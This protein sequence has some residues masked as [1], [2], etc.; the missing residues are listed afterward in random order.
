MLGIEGLSVRLSW[1]AR[2]WVRP[3]MVMLS[4]F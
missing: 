1:E 2:L 4:I 3:V